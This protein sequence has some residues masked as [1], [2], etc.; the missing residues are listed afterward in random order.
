MVITVLYGG[1]QYRKSKEEEFR[2]RFWEEQYA[3]YSKAVSAAAVIVTAEDFN[4]VSAARQEFWQLYW[5]P[6]C[7]LEDPQVATAMV[8]F[9]GL[10]TQAE[11]AGESSQQPAAGPFRREF[12]KA[13]HDLAHS[14]RESLSR[15]WQPV[16]L[17]ELSGPFSK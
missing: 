4:S 7:M 14:M 10:L 17:G 6:M 12:R 1:W 2:K 13:A 16:D 5:G 15:T 8:E 9:G 11:K 3:L